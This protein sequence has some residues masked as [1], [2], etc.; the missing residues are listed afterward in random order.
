VKGSNDPKV[1]TR[2]C[3]EIKLQASKVAGDITSER[4]FMRMNP[5][6]PNVIEFDPRFLVFEFT[7]S[8]LLRKS[9]V[10]LVHKFMDQLRNNRSMCHQ[11]IMGAGKTTV[12]TP[13]LALMLA[14]GKSLVM[15]VVPHA[16]LEFSRG[17]MREKFAAVV[18]KPVFTF[19]FDRSTPISRELYLKLCKARDSKAVVCAT[20][21]SVKSFMLKFVE[22]MR[23]LEEQKYGGRQKKAGFFSLS[24][25]AQRFKDRSVITEMKVNPEDVYYCSEIL[26]LFRTGVLLLDEVDLILH[27]LKSELNWPIGLKEPIDFSSSRIG[28]GL[29]WD[30]QWHVL[31]AIFYASSKRMSV[32]FKDSREAITI[33]DSIANLIQAGISNKY[34][35]QTPHL[36]LLNRS[37]YHR[38][39]KLLMARWQLLYLRNKRLPSVEDKHLLSY[40]VNG[41]VKDR[42]AASA[43]SV[44]LDDEYMKLLNL[45]HDLLNNFLPFMLGKIDRV[46]FG[47]LAKQDLKAA[48]DRGQHVSLT[49]RLSAIPY[50]G[51]DIPS[52]ASQFSHPD[53]VIGLTILAFR[54]EGIRFSDF[55]N[56]LLELRERLDSEYGPFHKRP[57]SL[58]FVQWV[59][60][61][62]GKVRGPREGENG[63]TDDPEAWMRA[64]MNGRAGGRGADDIWPLYLLDLKDDHHMST[65]YK[66]LRSIPQVI[67]F[68]LDSFV[69]PL[70]MEHHREKISAS[71]QDLGGQMLF[72]KRVGF[73]GT[74]SDL[75]P[76]ELGQCHYEECVDGQILHYLTTE[77]IVTSRL[78]PANW[79]VKYLLDQ[80]AT[81]DPPFHV[82]LD[83]G[84]LITGMTNFQVAKYLLT[85]GLSEKFDGVVYLDDKDRKMI[86]MKH[87]MNVVRLNQ[88]GIPPDRRFSFYDQ[89]HTTGMD[90]HQCIDAKAVLTL[91]KDMTFR[92]Y[93]QGAF[94]MRGIGLGQTIELFII[95]EVLRL[96]DDEQKRAQ[97]QAGIAAPI[98]APN[99][100]SNVYGSD[101]LSL[102]SLATP[103]GF[104]SA[105]QGAQLLINVAA[106]LTVN[107]MKSENVQFRMLCHQSVDNVM[108]KRA[109]GT[110]TASYTE[111][112]QMA[113]ASR[114]KEFASLTASSSSESKGDSSSVIEEVLEGSRKLFAD[115]MVA[116]RSL[117]QA[118]V[119]GT[120]KKA[121]PP[122]GI[123][124]IQ[125]CLDMLTERL[126]N[127]IQN[128]IPMSVALSETIRNNVMRN[129]Q[130]VDTDYDKAVV[131][132]I[133]MVL[134]NSEQISKRGGGRFIEIEEVEEDLDA[135]LQREQVAEE[136]VLQEQEEEEEEVRIPML[137]TVCLLGNNS[138]AHFFFFP[139]GGRGT[140]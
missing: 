68:Y 32:A 67:Q 29:R 104:Q 28:A 42:E 49:R 30:V 25:L 88:A 93:A 21:T 136:E 114:V 128:N 52:R 87:G 72:G 66:L 64:P 18:R 19:S 4:H 40:M 80:I 122:V 79:S 26:K 85:N 118:G 11:M 46:S 20:P 115:D 86:L 98:Q 135:D 23:H 57:S 116:I 73:S 96:I 120:S 53:V 63:D 6:N 54:Y 3:Q 111:L 76:E 24:N 35:Q 107:G 7:Y 121:P 71:G 102:S 16:L 61:A 34:I 17:V 31:D 5:S 75:L 12:V 97:K 124:T 103:V 58:L 129:A 139:A 131:D 56:V 8:L 138:N 112:T 89:I 77:S 33:L 81:N 70:T 27:P 82:L 137:P 39:M 125:K 113:F 15:Q 108:R 43:V 41:P 83:T 37:F 50:V 69:F 109:Y 100:N 132:K 62:G 101:I 74:P 94:R 2:V 38:E 9:Q 126:D 92:D 90:I 36:V 1:R 44:A 134:V 14:D 13:L 22:M 78:L 91:G 123:E 59:E 45:S 51:K 10:V 60:E 65:T 95:P 47:L 99:T 110:L 106:W 127:T 130:F 117:V 48:L 119:G 84:A 140:D 55:E 133:L 105:S